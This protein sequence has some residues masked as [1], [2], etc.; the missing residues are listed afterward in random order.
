MGLASIVYNKSLHRF[1]LRFNTCSKSYK[2]GSDDGDELALDL[3]S[4]GV[5]L[6]VADGFVP[7]LFSWFCGYFAH[8][9][10]YG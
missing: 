2:E 6:L 3:G 7:M 1:Y 5:F 10:S 8:W 4:V 9:T